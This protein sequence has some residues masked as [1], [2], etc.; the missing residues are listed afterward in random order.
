MIV[1]AVGVVF[2]GWFNARGTDAV[3]LISG[4]PPIKVGHVAVDHATHDTALRRPVTDP[5][6]RAV[7]LGGASGA[8]RDAVLARHD[9]A[10]LETAGGGLHALD[11]VSGEVR[12]RS[13]ITGLGQSRPVVAG[14][15]VYAGDSAGTTYALNAATGTL[16]WSFRAEGDQPAYRWDAAVAD[17]LVYTAGADRTL[18]ALDAATGRTRWRLP[19][20]GG[21]HTGPVAAGG[22]LYVSDVGGTLYALDPATGTVRSRSWTGGTVQ[23][24]PVVSDGFVYVGGSNGNLYAR[25]TAGP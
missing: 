17:G 24:G 8:R 1:A 20:G 22:T 10:P 16:L 11:A 12:W 21:R 4:E 9:W 19:L 14:A 18:Y 6:D 23:T 3:D 15:T 5:A 13:R 2:T 7:L 25:P